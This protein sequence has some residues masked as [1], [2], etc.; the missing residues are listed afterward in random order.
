M[1]IENDIKLDF[2]DVLLVPQRSTLES[3]SQVQLEREFH[4]YHSPRIW[5]GIP[6]ICSNMSCIAGFQMSAALQRH[7]MITCL[8]KYF[9]VDQL[10]EGFQK[11]NLDPDYTWISIGFSDKEIERLL[12]FER[13]SGVTP[14]IC[15]DVPNAYIQIFIDYCRRVRGFFYDSIIMAG[16]VTTSEMTQE[17]II[18]GKVD[19]VKTQIG[20]GCFPNGTLVRSQ[21]GKKTIEKVKV[22]ELVLTHKGQYKKVLARQSRIHDGFL[23][24][25]NGIQCTPNHEFYVVHIDDK[26]KINEENIHKYAKWISAEDLSEDYFLVQIQE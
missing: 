24:D 21:N 15:I 14:N 11:Y 17:L 8:H 6:I 18:G 20:P 16:N 19:I 10:V 9:T 26:N 3:R 2:D 7:K 22:G 13:Y 25:I 23:I 12:E 1:Y 5:K 4:F